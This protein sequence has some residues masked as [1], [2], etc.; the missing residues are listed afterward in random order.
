[1]A[2]AGRPLVVAA[3]LET[4]LGATLDEPRTDAI[5][6][7]LVRGAAELQVTVAFPVE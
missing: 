1:M 4:A 5:V 7:D 2:A 3:D 6:I